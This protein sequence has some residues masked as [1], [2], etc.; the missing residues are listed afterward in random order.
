MGSDGSAYV[1]CDDGA[2]AVRGGG[3]TR[4]EMN[5]RPRGFFAIGIANGKTETNMGTLWRSASLFGASFIFTVGRR[6]RQQC[7]DTMKSWRSI[8][9]FHFESVED[10][11]SALPYSCLLVGV[12]LDGRAHELERFVHP[13][14]ACYLLGAEDHG[15]TLAQRDDC[16][17]LVQLPGEW[18]MNVAAAG[19]IVLYDRHAKFSVAAWKAVAS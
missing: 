7:S 5:R 19:S 1:V 4:R 14:R 11:R 9:L 15:L 3:M 10:L 8:P 6:Y 12:E 17:A 2:G 13:E 18:S 16:H